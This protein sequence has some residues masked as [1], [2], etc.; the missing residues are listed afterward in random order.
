GPR[1]AAT[2]TA[3]GVAPRRRRPGDRPAGVRG[4]R[5]HL[6]PAGAG[7]GLL[8]LSSWP[9]ELRLV[10]PTSHRVDVLH[11]VDRLAA[12][13]A[14]AP[15]SSWVPEV[16]RLL[17]RLAGTIPGATATCRLGPGP[18]RAAAAAELAQIVDTDAAER[19]RTADRAREQL[20]E[21][22]QTGRDTPGRAGRSRRGRSGRAAARR[23]GH[24]RR[25]RA[26]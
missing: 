7:A 1:C 8:A 16:D 26:R 5:A 15:E 24:R 14:A 17:R 25:R 18:I 23:R 2:S 12:E 9:L 6:R 13:L 10:G 4:A 3:R 19:S 11:A 22:R 21:E 20:E